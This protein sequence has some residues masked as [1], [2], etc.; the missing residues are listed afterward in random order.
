[1]IRSGSTLQYNIARNII[2][3]QKIGSVEGYFQ[4]MQFSKLEDRLTDWENDTAY[5]L[6]KA[7]DLPVNIFKK[8]PSDSIKILYIYR[9]IRDVAASAKDKLKLTGKELLQSL[10]KALVTYERTKRTLAKI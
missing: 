7:H 5:H 2:E 10:D 6:I 3:K 4:E 8:L 1:M 9:D